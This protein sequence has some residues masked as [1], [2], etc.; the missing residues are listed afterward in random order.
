M[1]PTLDLSDMSYKEVEDE[2]TKFLSLWIGKHFCAYFI[3]G[4]DKILSDLVIKTATSHGL[5]YMTDMPG[6]PDR[7]RVIML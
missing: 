3:T 1:V 7:V 5:E 6:Y 2:V 4:G